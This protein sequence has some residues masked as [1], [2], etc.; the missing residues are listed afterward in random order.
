MLVSC[1]LVRKVGAQE[2][3]PSVM[4]CSENWVSPRFSFSSWN[5]ITLIP[6][7]QHM[8]NVSGCPH[9]PFEK[10]ILTLAM[11]GN[12]LFCFFI[13]LA[14]PWREKERE[15]QSC[16][17]R[18]VY[19]LYSRCCSYL[20]YPRLSWS[21]YLDL[22]YDI[23]PDQVGRNLWLPFCSRFG[24]VLLSCFWFRDSPLFLQDTV[25]FVCW[26]QLDFSQLFFFEAAEVL[27]SADFSSL[28]FPILAYSSI[29]G[30]LQLL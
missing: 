11:Q 1:F 9:K 8:P 14:F 3:C 10:A 24:V 7:Q 22:R 25:G 6:S 18:E 12:L 23:P 4:A 29:P 19:F 30:E 13:P 17:G 27:S 20:S 15:E 16:G 2:S 5:D 21:L 26:C 28:L